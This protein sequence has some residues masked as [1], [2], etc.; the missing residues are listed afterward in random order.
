M[1][2]LPRH[3]HLAAPHEAAKRNIE[4]KLRPGRSA[5][6][7]GCRRSA[8]PTRT[9]GRTHETD[10]GLGSLGLGFGGHFRSELLAEGLS[11][12]GRLLPHQTMGNHHQRP[13]TRRDEAIDEHF[14][15]KGGNPKGGARLMG[16][17]CAARLFV[18]SL[19][20]DTIVASRRTK[21]GLAHLVGSGGHRR[22]ATVATT[23]ADQEC[24][25]C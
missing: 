22:A 20:D 6:L 10:S 8:R 21:R 4:R 18:I 1:L 16:F 13:A 11:A 2:C 7:F 9:S 5:G 19:H 3:A 17:P 24:S 23:V 12:A 14:A 15:P 25:A